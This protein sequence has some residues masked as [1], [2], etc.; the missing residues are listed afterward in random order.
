MFLDI[1]LWADEFGERPQKPLDKCWTGSLM[2]RGQ[3][4]GLCAP[5]TLQRLCRNTFALCSLSQG[6]ALGP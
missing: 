3:T 2:V 4:I 5:L 6:S 1:Y